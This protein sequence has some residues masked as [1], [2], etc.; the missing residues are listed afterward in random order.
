MLSS[1]T[2]FGKLGS[3]VSD[4]FKLRFK[5]ISSLLV[6]ENLKLLCKY[7]GFCNGHIKNPGC[8]SLNILVIFK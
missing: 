1:K 5:K 2:N 3:D 4:H 7:I 6:L 8:F